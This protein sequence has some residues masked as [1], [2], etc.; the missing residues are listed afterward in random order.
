[1]LKPGMLD[2]MNNTFQNTAF[3]ISVNVH[4]T[5]LGI[6]KYDIVSDQSYKEKQ[7]KRY[8]SNQD[9]TKG[10][11]EGYLGS[12]LQSLILCCGMKFL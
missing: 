6:P 1:M 4:L 12:G 5:N 7:M 10:G 2:H 11:G 3:Q 8:L 9:W